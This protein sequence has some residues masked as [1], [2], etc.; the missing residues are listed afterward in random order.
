M[1]AFTGNGLVRTQKSASANN[2]NRGKQISDRLVEVVGYDIPNKTMHAKELIKQDGQ[3][4]YI[5]LDVKVDAEAIRRNEESAK[6]KGLMNT[7]KFKGHMID[8]KMARDIKTLAVLERSEITGKVSKD[9]EDKFQVSVQRIINVPNPEK[10]KTFTGIFTVSAYDNKVSFVQHWNER[11]VSIENEV[12]IDK[13]SKLMDEVVQNYGEKVKDRL[14]V[15]PSIGVQLRAIVPFTDP[16]NPK[17][18]FQVIDT[19]GPLDYIPDQKDD[20]GE[21]VQKGHP[22]DSEN[23]KQYMNGYAEHIRANYPGEEVKIEVCPYFNYRA[24]TQSVSLTLKDIAY[25]P[26]TQMATAKTRLSQDEE[27]YWVGKNWAVKGIVQ[28]SAD[29]ADIENKQLTLVDTYYVNKLHANNIKGHIHS[30]VNS[31]DGG[32]TVPHPMLQRIRPEVQ[33]AVSNDVPEMRSE[34]PAP[35]SEDMED[36][37]A[38]RSASFGK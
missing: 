36:P 31:S 29:H 10:E 7:A 9:K 37:F 13:L 18:K 35:Q 5:F 11:A 8:E 30:W 26:I 27:S 21:V 2:Q 6:E 14:V 23:F 20:N 38:S 32:K 19:S 33:R 28:I 22:L 17:T 12:E 4:K 34:A 1:V 15:R 24:S 25:D 16:E 3:E